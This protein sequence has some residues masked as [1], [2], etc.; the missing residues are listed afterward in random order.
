MREGRHAVV[1][2]PGLHVSDVHVEVDADPQLCQYRLLTRMLVRP[3]GGWSSPMDITPSGLITLGDSRL[4]SPDAMTRDDLEDAARASIHALLR[5][6]ADEHL[7]LALNRPD[8]NPH[9]RESRNYKPVISSRPR[10]N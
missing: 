7:A 9:T 3:V 5:H 10:T 2:L 4:L 6:E 1:H 8:W